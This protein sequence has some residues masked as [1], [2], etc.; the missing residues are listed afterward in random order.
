MCQDCKASPLG[1]ARQQALE[2][3]T[4]AC[5]QAGVNPQISGFLFVHRYRGR[6]PHGERLAL[7]REQR[8]ALVRYTEAACALKALHQD[9]VFA[10]G[11]AYVAEQRAYRA[12]HVAQDR[13]TLTNGH[14]P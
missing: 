14:T 9:Y 3:A 8:A 11:R 10:R 7:D 2:A 1:Q 12:A 6:V 5:Q 13:D 4:V